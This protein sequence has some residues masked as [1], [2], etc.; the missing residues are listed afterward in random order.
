V[1]GGIARINVETDLPAPLGFVSALPSQFPETRIQET[2]GQLGFRKATELVILDAETIELCEK[3][4]GELM[5]KI[6]SL[7]GDALIGFGQTSPGL[8]A[9]V[10]AS[11]GPGQ[12]LMGPPE[13][14]FTLSQKSGCG[15]L[16]AS[17][18]DDEVPHTVVDPGNVVG[19][20]RSWWFRG[21]WLLCHQGDPP[22]STGILRDGG[23]GDTAFDGSGLSKTHPPNFGKSDLPW[24]DFDALGDA[25]C[26]AIVFLRFELRETSGAIEKALKRVGEILKSLLQ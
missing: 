12:G 16:L 19:I 6:A 21:H 25:E 24:L 1:R 8:R 10:T 3:L 2:F 23:R 17:G 20:N 22:V 13:A 4:V 9:I 5:E 15:H 26:Q 18:E 14:S 11:L 7:I